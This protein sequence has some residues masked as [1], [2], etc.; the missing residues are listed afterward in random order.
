MTQSNE[1]AV[2]VRDLSFNY[3][4]RR[5]L[6]GVSFSVTPGEIFG[7]LGPNGS[8]KTTLFRLL[9]TLLAAP[10]G[11]IFLAGHDVARDVARVRSS[12]GVVFQSPSLDGKLS[13]RENLAHHG[14]LYGLRGADL[15]RRIDARLNGLGLTDRHGDRVETLS[16]GLKRRV[17][18]AKGLLSDPKILILDEPSTGLDP[19]A[20]RELWAE[21][22]T[23]RQT[24]ETTILVTTH[25]ID[26]A[27]RCDRIAFL[28]QGC[29]ATMGSPEE[30]K[31]RIGG[32]MVNIRT[33]EP[34]QL[35]SALRQDYGLESE[36][37]DGVLRLE[38]AN[39]HLL[40]KQ[41]YESHARIIDSISIGHPTLEDVFIAETGRS[42]WQ[43]TESE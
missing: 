32:D 2:L 43:P 6:D 39:G 41:L 4:Q 19:R 34:D 35:Q 21:L 15:Q 22:A 7:L 24:V 3:G 25:L 30:L 1:F 5:A 18:L 11:T 14:S 31:Q 28:D 38:Q 23:L 10:P 40:I 29:L 37:V 33:S 16:G 13:V 12:L 27:E 36:C 42:L 26:E 17:E 20:R 8:G 9:S